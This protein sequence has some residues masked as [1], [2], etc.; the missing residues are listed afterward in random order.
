VVNW[1]CNMSWN[2]GTTVAGLCNTSKCPD[3]PRLIQGC[4][5]WATSLL[6]VGY[7]DQQR[8]HQESLKQKIVEEHLLNSQPSLILTDGGAERQ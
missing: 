7:H 8:F 3:K 6:F 1:L 2:G 4:T 5:F